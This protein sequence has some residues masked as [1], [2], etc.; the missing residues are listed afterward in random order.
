MLKCESR[1]SLHAAQHRQPGSVVMFCHCFRNGYS[2]PGF[3]LSFFLNFSPKSRLLFLLECTPFFIN[4]PFLTL[5]PKIVQVFLRNR[6]KKLFSNCLV[7]GLLI[8]ILLKLPD[9]CD[10]FNQKTMHCTACKFVQND[11]QIQGCLPADAKGAHTVHDK[12]IPNVAIV[13]YGDTQSM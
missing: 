8:S 13:Y 6:P 11:L 12:N 9:T 1:T 2:K 10:P 4:N 7:D 3:V 5:A